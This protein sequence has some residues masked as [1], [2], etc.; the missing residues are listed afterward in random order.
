M[1]Y[2]A[3]LYGVGVVDCIFDVRVISLKSVSALCL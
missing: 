2:C 1:T 3:M